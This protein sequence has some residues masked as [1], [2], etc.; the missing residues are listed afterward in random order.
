MNHYLKEGV[1]PVYCTVKVLLHHHGKTGYKY[2]FL[3]E[4]YP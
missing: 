1:S 4:I 3:R 2:D